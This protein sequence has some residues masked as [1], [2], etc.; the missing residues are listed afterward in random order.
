MMYTIKGNTSDWEL[1]IGLEVHCQIISKAKVFS[2]ASAE[3]GAEQNTHVSLVDA[4]FPGMLP[5][6]NEECIRQ[7]V[8]TGLGLNAK[9]NKYSR[10]DRKNY[11][12]ADLPQ[13]YQIS[14]LYYPIVGEGFIEVHTSE[15]DR[16]I[17]VERL[18]LEQDAG[19][20]IHDMHPTKSFIDL[21]RSGVGLMEIVSKPDMRSP[22]EAG[23]YLRQL[24][25]IVRALGTCDGNMDEGSMRCDVN[26]SVR[27]VGE[28]ILRDRVEVKNVN[29]VRFV[30]QAIEI[31]ANRQVEVYENGGT[32][33]QETRLFD[34]NNNETRPMRSKE[35]AHDYRYFPDP[36][37][38]PVI[39]TD[40]YIE[41]IRA[42]L[43]ELPEAKKKRYVSE[44]GLTDYDAHVLTLDVETSRYF[45]EAM[46][47]QDP[48]KVANW[49]MG[50]LF[51]YLNKNGLTVSN[52]PVSAK[53]LG[54][55]VGLIADGTISGKIAK[56]VFEI[57]AE[58][59]KE[60]AVIVEEKGLKQE[61]DTGAIEKL[62]EEILSANQDKVAEIKAGKDKLKGWFV[63]QIMKASGGKVNPALA[64]QLLDKK[65]AE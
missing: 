13:G 51:G 19:K 16:K 44:L 27:K 45:E 52:S 12:Y 29:S 11:F 21:N 47:G 24:R 17:G 40:E 62:I 14:Q 61:S 31:E 39:L 30:M 2:G 56:D 50:D 22:E 8:K 58:T 46:I 18:H 55:L 28:T 54:A 36:D 23:E 25:A 35:N 65:L 10:F 63:G 41:E 34:P 20:S 49:V 15:G 57:M 60:P 64:N 33:R 38:L 6:L 37:L 7:S 53:N 26:V 43:P 32:V 5:V 59:G 9:I 1:V 48:K 3:F 4:A 42:S